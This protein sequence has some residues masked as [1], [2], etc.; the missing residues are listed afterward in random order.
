MIEYAPLPDKIRY[1]SLFTGI[2]GFEQ[3]IHYMYPNAECVGYSEIKPSAIQIYVSHFPNHNNLGDITEIDEEKVGTCDLLCAG[4]P[5]TNLSSLARINGDSRGLDG[6]KSGLFHDMIRIM[7]TLFKKNPNM[8]FIIENNASMTKANR[9]LITGY[10]KEVC[11]KRV[12]M[13]PINSATLGVQT[14]KRLYWTTFPVS[15][16]Q[17]CLQT[18]DDVLIP[19]EYGVQISDK[20]IACMNRTIP[21]KKTYE[22]RVFYDGTDFQDL[23]HDETSRSRWQCSFHSDTTEQK[24]THYHYPIGKCRPITAS[25]GNHNV[26][27][28]RRRLPFK[29][30]MFEIEEM[31]KLFGYEPGYTNTV[32]AKSKKRDCLGNTVVVYVIKHI[33]AHM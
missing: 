18:W 21:S 23:P 6:K 31:E 20:Y 11:P 17:E 2:G 24:L 14:R 15:Q 25:F 4:F 26:L 8:N 30:R 1:L 19:W 16:P 3:A 33:L 13:T 5:C 9:A 12:Y 29:I 32:T 28:D 10:L 27:V 22:H 7:K